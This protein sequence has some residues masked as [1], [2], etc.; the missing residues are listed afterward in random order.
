VRILTIE[1]SS[2]HETVGLVDAGRILA[3][4]TA[5]AGRG[6]GVEFLEVVLEALEMGGSRAAD[7]DLI[8]VSAGPGRFTGLRVGM[9]T[10]KGLALAT[11]V[12]VAPVSTLHALAAASGRDGLVAPLIDA[13]RGEVYAALFED[14][15]RLI[16]DLACGPDALHDAF[17]DFDG[18]VAFVGGGAVAY[19]EEL[20]RAFGGSAVV[21]PDAP[22]APDPATLAAL[23]ECAP[24]AA[25]EEMEPVYVRGVGAARPTGSRPVE[26]RG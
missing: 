21:D 24:R 13:R 8:A 5:E 16:E 11:G 3:A 15:R 23:A 2:V 6:R 4:R 19:A 7:L 1:T 26:P 14:G 25:L 17:P 9:A 22:A 20:R 10:A 18:T 12:P